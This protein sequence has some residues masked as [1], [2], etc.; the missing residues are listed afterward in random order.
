MIV[1][2]DVSST[3]KDVDGLVT[4]LN[5]LGLR[6]RPSRG[7]ERTVIGVVGQVFPELADEL[8]VLSGVED[9][10]RVSRAY[11]LPSREFHPQDTVIRVGDVVIGQGSVVVMAG[12]CAV[13]G[14]EQLMATA[15]AVKA[16]GGHILRGGAYKPRTSPSAFRGLGEDGLRIPL[17]AS[18]PPH[19]RGWRAAPVSCLPGTGIRGRSSPKPRKADGDVR[20][21]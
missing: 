11:K 10:V 20:G 2:I 15:R 4:R 17:P 9:V 6:G 14:E 16:A 18:P 1:V 7:A 13:E 5:E 8:G 21:L 3:E 12:P 19:P